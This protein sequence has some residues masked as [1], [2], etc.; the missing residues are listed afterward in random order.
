MKRILGLR[1]SV[2]FVEVSSGSVG[3]DDVDVDDPD[4]DDDG[5][6][7]FTRSRRS[8]LTSVVEADSRNISGI[9]IECLSSLFIVGCRLLLL[10]GNDIGFLRR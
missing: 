10:H 4:S 5:D 2:V 9:L 8:F 1:R 3:D 6:D 7:A